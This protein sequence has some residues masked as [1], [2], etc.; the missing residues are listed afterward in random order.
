MFHD[1]GGKKHICLTLAVVTHDCKPNPK[2]SKA[3]ELWTEDQAS[4]NYTVILK[5]VLITSQKQN[6]QRGQQM[7]SLWGLKPDSEVDNSVVE[8]L[9]AKTWPKCG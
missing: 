3:R 4:E 5:P 9:H 1:Q 7:Y 2:E 6:K 8:P